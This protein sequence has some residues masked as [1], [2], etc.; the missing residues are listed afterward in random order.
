MFPEKNMIF[1]C[2]IIALFLK[3]CSIEID[4]IVVKKHMSLFEFRWNVRKWKKES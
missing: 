2:S 3:V 4:L 1:I